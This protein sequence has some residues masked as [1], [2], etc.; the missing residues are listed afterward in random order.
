MKRE[1]IMSLGAGSDGIGG[2]RAGRDG[3]R[4]SGA[5]AYGAFAVRATIFVAVLLASLLLIAVDV[6]F[7][8][9]PT[10]TDVMTAM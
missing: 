8:V 6:R 7:G 10:E 2:F 1:A 3:G 9:T 5:A 4:Q